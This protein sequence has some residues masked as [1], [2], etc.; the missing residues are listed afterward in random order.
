MS[1]KTA[2]EATQL[3]NDAVGEMRIV[4]GWNLSVPTPFTATPMASAPPAETNEE[5]EVYVPSYR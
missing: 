4:A 3:I 2:V 5:P 1:G